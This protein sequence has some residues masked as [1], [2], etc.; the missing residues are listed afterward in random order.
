MVATYL[1]VVGA[2]NTHTVSDQ[3]GSVRA[4]STVHSA[5]AGLPNYYNV[6]QLVDATITAG[7]NLSGAGLTA[8]NLFS[9]LGRHAC[10]A[11]ETKVVADAISGG[12]DTG[13]SWLDQ[14]GLVAA[15]DF[16][17]GGGTPRNVAHGYVYKKIPRKDTLN[18]TGLAEAPRGALGHW[19][20]IQDQKI[21]SYQCVVPTTWNAC[22]KGD[23]NTDRGPAESVLQGIPACATDPAGGDPTMLNDAVLNIARML[24][25]YDF[26]IACAVHVVTPEGK[27][28]AKFEMGT[29]GKITKYPVDSE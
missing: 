3:G 14:L 13:S 25:P 2:T 28:L 8:N 27:E 15:T 20:T 9:P 7:S 24:H 19:I 26:C 11:L 22:P 18:G 5:F 21:A 12:V 6:K 16:D 1:A 29:D 4:L 23:N 17:G 10:R